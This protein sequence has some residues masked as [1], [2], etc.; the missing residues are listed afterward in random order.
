VRVTHFATPQHLFCA[1]SSQ[2][3]STATN[4][5]GDDDDDGT[6]PTLFSSFE[7]FSPWKREESAPTSLLVRR[8]THIKTSSM[9]KIDDIN[10]SAVRLRSRSTAERVFRASVQ[11]KIRALRAYRVSVEFGDETVSSDEPS[12]RDLYGFP[13]KPPYWSAYC[14]WFADWSGKQKVL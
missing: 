6:P 12:E 1:M 13:V 2:P 8:S 11:Q 10:S 3:N 7:A 4:S 9:S 14:D 5:G